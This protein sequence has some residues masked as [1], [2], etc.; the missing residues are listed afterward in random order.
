MM[1]A[2]SKKKWRR[3]SRNQVEGFKR[4]KRRPL[5]VSLRKSYKLPSLLN[6]PTHI[7]HGISF[8]NCNNTSA[9]TIL[10]LATYASVSFSPLS[11]IFQHLSGSFLKPLADQ[12]FY[13][14]LLLLELLS[15]RQLY[16]QSQLW[17]YLN[18]FYENRS[19]KLFSVS[20]EHSL[21]Q[22]STIFSTSYA[23]TYASL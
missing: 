4:L 21:L 13:T 19:W 6:N 1:I 15:L 3:I 20:L 23:A 22:V 9:I 14:T 5:L 16:P 17:S 11:S 18:N 2:K 12:Q 10:L 7:L 8:V